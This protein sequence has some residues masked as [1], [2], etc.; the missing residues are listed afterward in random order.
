MLESYNKS[1]RK[2]RV[3]DHHGGVILYVKGTIFY[4]RREDLEISG[5]ENIWIELAN[6]HKCILFFNFL[7]TT[8]VYRVGVLGQNM[9]GPISPRGSGTKH[10]GARL[11]LRVL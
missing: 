8:V 10:V 3:G 1:E 9:W 5:V 11:I 4:K 7:S 6:N 2:D